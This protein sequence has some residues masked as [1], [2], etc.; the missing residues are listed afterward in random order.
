[1]ADAKITG[2]MASAKGIRHSFGVSAVMHGI[3]LSTLRIWMGH[4]Y[5]ETTTIYTRVTGPEELMLAQ[6]MWNDLPILPLPSSSNDR[7]N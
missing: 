1:M 4:A 2:L 5:I 7:N 6:R 3:P